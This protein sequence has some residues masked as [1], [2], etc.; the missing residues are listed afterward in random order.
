MPNVL[1]T[2]ILLTHTSAALFQYSVEQGILPDSIG[3]AYW[4]VNAR[5]GLKS[6]DGKFE[7]FVSGDNLF[8]QVYYINGSGSSFNTTLNYGNPRII[9]GGV[10]IDF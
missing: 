7:I 8:N 9:R 1:T 2:D 3:P 4:L 10:T 5:L 6:N